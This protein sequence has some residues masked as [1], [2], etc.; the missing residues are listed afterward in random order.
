MG[1]V[2]K[3]NNQD[4][5]SSKAIIV[6]IGNIIKSSFTIFVPVI[7]VRLMSKY[8][9][10][11]YRQIM[12]IYYTFSPILVLGIPKSIYYFFPR[13]IEEK[14]RTFVF[15][16]IYILIILGVIVLL[17]LYFLAGEIASYFNNSRLTPL[18]KIICFSFIFGL[19]LQCFNPIM[20]CLNLHKKSVFTNIFYVLLTTLSIIL[21][22]LLGYNLDVIFCSLIL[23]LIIQFL[24]F[25]FL[26]NKNIVGKFR[27][28]KQLI[29]DQFKYGLPVG[30]SEISGIIN[31]QLDKFF[32][33][34]YY[35]PQQFAIYSIGARELPFVNLITYSISNVIQPRLVELHHQGRKSDF[36]R[37]WHESTRKTA[38]VIF[39]IFVFFFIMAEEF[40]VLLFTDSYIESVIFLKVYLF[41]L[42]FRISAY[43]PVLL[44]MGYPKIV[45]MASILGLLFNI[46]FNYAFINFFG[47]IGPAYAT[48]MINLFLFFYLL[49]NIKIKLDINFKEVLPWNKILQIMIVSSISGTTIYL[50]FFLIN[51]DALLMFSINL[52]IFGISYVIIAYY[53]KIFSSDDMKL[54]KSW[55]RFS[56]LK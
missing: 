10:G 38:L 40:I 46:V 16:S 48:V 27:I 37:L 24:Y 39:P 36:I 4:R 45:F 19:P 53:T 41:V 8:D 17:I 34:F 15:Q 33:S 44:A 23:S 29:K 14:R 2:K 1:D 51:T 20:F 52:I 35:L 3:H 22:V 55:L 49:V 47:M 18:I 9:Y 6:L 32:I 43:G 21:P 5:L 11:S 26:I 54:A 42:I 28:E 25:V 13:L 56:F 50:I 31:R 12:L 30:F 7:L